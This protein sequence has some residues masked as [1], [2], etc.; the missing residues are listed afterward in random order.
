[1]TTGDR[2]VHVETP[3]LRRVVVETFVG[4][5]GVA[6]IGL[7]IAADQRWWDHHFLP[8]FDVPRPLYT[9]GEFC[10]R[11]VLAVLGAALALAA[12]PR[13]GRL[14]ARLPPLTFAAATARV[15]LAILLALGSSELIL[16]GAFRYGVD[17][18]RP[19]EEPLCA[20]DQRLGWFF[21]PA[22]SAQIR[23]NGR[24]IEYAFDA[25]GNRVRRPG[26]QVDPESPTILFTGESIM[27]GY[28]LNWDE[29]VPAQVGGL[30]GVQS[31][32]LAVFGYSSGQAY[33]RLAEKLPH[34]RKPVAVVSL[35]APSLFDRNLLDDRPHFGTGLIWLP[36]AHR[37]R[38]AAL[39]KRVW[40][41]RSDAS[42]ERGVAITT[43]VLHASVNLAHARGAEPL[44]V[45]P[46]F[47]PEG[48]VEERLL[49]RILDETG[50]PYVLVK[51]DPSWHL[52]G[53]LHPDPRAAQAIAMAVAGRL[54][55]RGNKIELPG[56]HAE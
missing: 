24:D 20:L 54:Q 6:A 48:A 44:I 47:G 30:L 21:A 35:F 33:L 32:N 53:D 51:L 28:G 15:L 3:A 16:R 25:A 38:L 17:Q 9:L 40:P 10:A 7:A 18:P 27:A 29:S 43:A 2:S 50:L 34:F 49:R 12:R 45:V 1:M 36:A 13:L 11:G 26:E 55:G 14:A 5:M 31:A 52:L 42:I 4:L 37:W 41:Y 23:V 46:Q 19:D 8:I 39:V 22:H 56:A